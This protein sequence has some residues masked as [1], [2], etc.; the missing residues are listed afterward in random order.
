[1]GRS[2]RKC[3]HGKFFAMSS[4][5]KNFCGRTAGGGNTGT[6]TP[7]A[8]AAE[9]HRHPRFDSAHALA[10]TADGGSL[11]PAVS[12]GRDGGPLAAVCRA[13]GSVGGADGVR[14]PRRR[15]VRRVVAR[16]HRR[17]GGC[18]VAAVAM[19][20]PMWSAAWLAAAISAPL[21]T[22]VRDSQAGTQ[23]AKTRLILA[24]T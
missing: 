10:F 17:G 14:S 12:N 21:G 5:R 6:A 9:T 1:M 20:W 18:W 2:C 4:T 23:R 8:P 15:G 13:V 24:E 11:G 19:S 22:R 3:H 7:F 16:V